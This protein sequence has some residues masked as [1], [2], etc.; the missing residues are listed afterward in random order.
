MGFAKNM[1]HLIHKWG[2]QVTMI[3]CG[4]LGRMWAQN[5]LISSFAF[6]AS[7]NLA[8]VRV[9]HLDSVFVVDFH[10]WV[11]EGRDRYLS[12]DMVF[13]PQSCHH[14]LNS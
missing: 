14:A 9:D 1:V 12:H 5:C 11:E 13:Q 7:C 3:I 8:S 10:D 2:P 4:G 6:F